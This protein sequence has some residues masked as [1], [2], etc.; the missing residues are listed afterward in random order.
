MLSPRSANML[1]QAQ[2]RSGDL[3][4]AARDAIA[5]LHVWHG[6]GGPC[7]IG[8]RGHAAQCDNAILSQTSGSRSALFSC[9]RT[10][11]DKLRIWAVL[12]RL[13]PTRPWPRGFLEYFQ[14]RYTYQQLKKVLCLKATNRS[15]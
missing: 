1:P 12:R 15:W 5:A 13:P 6:G 2:L 14:G 8:E 7:R 3:W 11:G 4:A 10:N 9:N